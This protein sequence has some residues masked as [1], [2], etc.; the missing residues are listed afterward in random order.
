M[1]VHVQ[2]EA[3]LGVGVGV[4]NDEPQE[5]FPHD[6]KQ[7][8]VIHGDEHLPQAFYKQRNGGMSGGM[9]RVT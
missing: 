5:H 3:G 2:L 9:L 6:F 7:Y 4:A 8:P 1:S